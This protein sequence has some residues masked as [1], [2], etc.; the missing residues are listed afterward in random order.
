MERRDLPR[1]FAGLQV[2]AGEDS[3]PV[4]GGYGAVFYRAGVP[5]TELEL[6]RDIYERIAPTAFDRALR[7]DDTRSLFNH[8]ESIVLGSNRGNQPSLRLTID[9]VG[10]RYEVAPPD[11]QLV[12][13]QVLEP[14]RRGDV[15]GSSFMFVP[16]KVAWTEEQRDGRTVDIRELQDVELW[17][18]GPVTFPAYPATS[19]GLRAATADVAAIAEEVERR[20]AARARA[21]RT[22]EE[23]DAWVRIAL[24]LAE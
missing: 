20:R 10:L 4:I 8:D 5:G 22:R 17:E 24:R 2:R 7:E 23:T 11:T 19:A 15:S 9:S 6:F 16:R 18:V 21:K 3:K 14:I 1:A 12:R 13:D